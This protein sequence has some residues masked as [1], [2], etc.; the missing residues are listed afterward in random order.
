MPPIPGLPGATSPS[1]QSDGR[2]VLGLDDVVHE[3]VAWL[4]RDGLSLSPFA[5]K[6]TVQVM[7]AELTA[8]DEGDL[9]ALLR[10]VHVELRRQGVLLQPRQVERVLRVYASVIALLGIHPF[11][12]EGD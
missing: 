4:D 6:A 3:V 7:R 10:S 5:V 12:F 2:G 1:F 9:A 11:G 8:R